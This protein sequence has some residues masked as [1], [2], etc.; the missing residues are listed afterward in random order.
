[1]DPKFT[2]WL[3]RGVDTPWKWYLSSTRKSLAIREFGAIKARYPLADYP[4]LKAVLC[5]GRYS[6]RTL[7]YLLDDKDVLGTYPADLL[8]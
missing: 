7:P 2:I 3:K 1:M 5:K 6:D 8:D 4:H